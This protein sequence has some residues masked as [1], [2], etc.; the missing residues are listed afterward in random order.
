MDPCLAVLQPPR[1]RPAQ[2][3]PARAL[4]PGGTGMTHCTYL[5][6]GLGAHGWHLARFTAF[7]EPKGEGDALF[8]CDCGHAKT[9]RCKWLQD[10]LSIL[11]AT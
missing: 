2:P 7:L 8:V 9:V 4:H 11:E 10:H 3:R 5:R 6:P 1:W